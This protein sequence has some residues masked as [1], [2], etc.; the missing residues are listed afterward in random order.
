MKKYS[1][2]IGQLTVR[3][4]YRHIVYGEVR[5]LISEHRT[6]IG[7]QKSSQYDARICRNLG[8]GAFSDAYA[9][10]FTTEGWLLDDCQI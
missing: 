10:T 1:G 3:S 2:Y 7:A 6:A 9:F 5:G 4:N 8:A